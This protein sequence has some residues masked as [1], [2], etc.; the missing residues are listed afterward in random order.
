MPMHLI[1]GF[2]AD[3]IVLNVTGE[4]GLVVTEQEQ[5]S[6]TVVELETISIEVDESEISIATADQVSASFSVL[7]QTAVGLTVGDNEMPESWNIEIVRGATAT[8]RMTFTD[9]AGAAYDL[10]GAT[11]YWAFKKREKDPAAII[12]KDSG[13]VTEIEVIGAAT[14]GIADLKIVPSDTEDLEPGRYRHDLWIQTAAGDKLPVVKPSLF[15]IRWEVKQ[16]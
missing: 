15:D 16:P 9:S 10:T 11:I 1:Q 4:I 6:L 14:D 5:I 3:E 13:T 7:V 12:S 2:T 8:Y